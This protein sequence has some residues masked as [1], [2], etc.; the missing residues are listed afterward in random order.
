[1]SV[2]ALRE[3]MGVAHETVSGWLK[4]FASFFL[5]FLIRPWHKKVTR[6]VRK[7]PKLYLYDWALVPEPSA[8]LENM[9]ALHLLKAVTRW[10]EQGAGDFGLYFIR[11]REKN[12]V[13][14]L[15]S[16]DA[17][18]LLMIETKLGE[19]DPSP[20]LRKMKRALRVPAVQLNSRTG[21][22]RKAAVDDDFVLIASADRWLSM[23][24]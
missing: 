7:E 14:F 17:K 4:V 2:N 9:V 24:P 22:S 1:M 12:E 13:D 15:M 11:D 19:T 10:T 21:I 18:P 23:L 16:R 3:D 20:S 8:R 5:I 6:A